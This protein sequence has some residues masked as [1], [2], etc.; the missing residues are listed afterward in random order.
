MKCSLCGLDFQE[1]EG[2]ATCDGCA[3]ARSC[4]LIK[5][6]N[7]GYE[8]PREPKLLISLLSWIKRW[9]SPQDVTH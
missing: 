3:M 1:A 5:C 8:V 2:Q 4:N 9:R 6:P 7:C